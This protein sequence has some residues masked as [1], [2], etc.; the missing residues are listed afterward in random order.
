VGYYMA[1]GGTPMPA[2]NLEKGHRP[3]GADPGYGDP[4]YGWPA[5]RRMNKWNGRALSRAM[6]RVR[7]FERF[8][9]KAVRFTQRVKFRKRR[10]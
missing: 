2:F 4:G 3:P 6:T 5:A 10:R 8:A 9:R 7:S 1:G